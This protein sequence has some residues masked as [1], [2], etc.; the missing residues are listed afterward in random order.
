MADVLQYSASTL[1]NASDKSKLALSESQESKFLRVYCKACSTEIGLYNVLASSVSLFKWQV[2]CDTH[3][4][5]SW[6][7]SSQCLAAT[8]TATISRSGSSK[9]VIL[10]HSVSKI[11]VSTEEKLRALHLWVLNPS[12]TYASSQAVVDGGCNAMKILFQI[13]GTEQGDALADSLTTDVQ[14]ISLPVSVID[15]AIEAL[16]GSNLYLPEKERTFK[17]WRVGLLGRWDSSA[18]PRTAR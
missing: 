15:D 18:E 3:V 12:V 2:I 5:T 16:E 1:Q 6:P 11:N 10:P 13:I 9:S 8:L 7:A 17:E 4:P 14:D